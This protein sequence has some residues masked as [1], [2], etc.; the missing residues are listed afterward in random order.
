[1]CLDFPGH[2]CS[3][4]IPHA[5]K[6]GGEG[7]GNMCTYLIRALSI[8]NEDPPLNKELEQKIVGKQPFSRNLNS[9]SHIEEVSMPWVQG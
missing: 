9:C 6:G 3:I 2:L 7:N 5:I 4:C 1:M 8:R